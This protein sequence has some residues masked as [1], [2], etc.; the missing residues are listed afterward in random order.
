[1]LN[2][3]KAPAVMVDVLLTPS[4]AGRI[5]GITSDAV[6][7]RLATERPAHRAIGK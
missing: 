7:C 4:E 5:L 3:A 1:M 2:A 6:R